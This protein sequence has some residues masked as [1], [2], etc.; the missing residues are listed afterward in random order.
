MTT[1][2]DHIL[3]TEI[4]PN[5]GYFVTI[6]EIRP[7]PLEAINS[8]NIDDFV[9]LTEDWNS[10]RVINL[11]KKLAALFRG[12]NSEKF[13]IILTGSDAR[14]ESGPSKSFQLVVLCVE[15]KVGLEVSKKLFQNATHLSIEGETI[16]IKILGDDDSINYYE[17]NHGNYWPC[18]I[19]NTQLLFGSALLLAQA[20]E[21]IISDF[22]QKKCLREDSGK[23]RKRF[24]NTTKNGSSRVGSRLVN[25]FDHKKGVINFQPSDY[26]R[27]LKYGPIRLLQY[28]LLEIQLKNSVQN[29][30]PNTV[31]KLI[32]L[33]GYNEEVILSYLEAL[34]SYHYQLFLTEQGQ[35]AILKVDSEFILWITQTILTFANS[36]TA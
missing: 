33:M 5:G 12:Y 10:E 34:K 16:E 27:G 14:R 35:P 13:T 20:R 2:L 17:S 11:M 23:N 32:A 18:R 21:K 28:F 25:H 24:K 6:N 26:V 31:E 29:V 1:K 9:T 4:N 19:L 30:D 3:A 22:H 7:Y 36:S 15:K 8:S